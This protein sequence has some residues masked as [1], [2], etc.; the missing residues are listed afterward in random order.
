MEVKIYQELKEKYGS[1]SSWAIWS[2]KNGK[3][4]SGMDDISFL[5]E[6]SELMNPNIILVGLIYIL[7]LYKPRLI[8]KSLVGMMG[9]R[10]LNRQK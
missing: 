8:M 3:E 4:K 7:D 1:M 2:D 6:Y 5:E 9:R 10:G